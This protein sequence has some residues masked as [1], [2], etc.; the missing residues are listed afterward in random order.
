MPSRKNKSKLYDV[1]LVFV[2]VTLVAAF[3][4]SVAAAFENMRF[5][6]ATSQ[7]LRFVKVTRAFAKDQQTFYM[8][9][10]QDVWKIMVQSGQ[11]VSSPEPKNPWE[12]SLKATAVSNTAVRI[13]TVL[14]AQ[15]CRRTVLYFLKY[16]TVD[17]G[18]LSIEAKSE[19][20]PLWTTA[21]PPGPATADIQTEAACG[22]TRRSELAL[23][24][25]IKNQDVFPSPP[26]LPAGSTIQG[27]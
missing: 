5:A 9:P 3:A 4:I 8:F 15:D 6:Q 10:G 7:I 1:V 20:S 13:E 2:S 24:F 27:P 19:Q 17:L 22:T 23:T 11:I 12:G 26:S 21:Y 16:D 25:R 18:L 14:P